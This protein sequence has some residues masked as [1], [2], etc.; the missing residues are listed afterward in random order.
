M[1]SF[2]TS[3]RESKQVTYRSQITPQGSEQLG[4]YNG[5]RRF[6]SALSIDR[7]DPHDR[8]YD[9]PKDGKGFGV[10]QPVRFLKKRRDSKTDLSLWW[11]T[12]AS[13][14]TCIDIA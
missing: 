11:R 3:C 4:L 1:L 6:D 12:M 13:E 7:V 5:M 14:S 2:K 9:P 8:R 10:I